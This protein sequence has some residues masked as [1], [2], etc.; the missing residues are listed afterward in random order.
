MDKKGHPESGKLTII[1]HY[2]MEHI[3]RGICSLSQDIAYFH[4]VNV[5]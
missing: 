5:S 3:T 2:E 1:F 4:V